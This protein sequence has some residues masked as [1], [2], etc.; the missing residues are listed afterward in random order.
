M[1]EW[2]KPTII[3]AFGTLLLG[4]IIRFEV[5]A[6]RVNENNKKISKIDRIEKILCLV[7][8]ELVGDEAMTL[9]VGNK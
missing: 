4:Y 3:I 5:L 8:R 6:A 2:R 7:A 1:K 9:C